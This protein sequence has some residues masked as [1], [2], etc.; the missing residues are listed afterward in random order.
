MPNDRK[1][2][3]VSRATAAHLK[4]PGRH[5]DRSN[6]KVDPVGNPPVYLDE[7]AKMAWA[8]FVEE[9]P[10]LGRSDRAILEMIC[11]LRAKIMGGGS[12]SLPAMTE[13]RQQLSK[14]GASPS[15][16]SKVSAPDGGEE[17]DP[18]SKYVQ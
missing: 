9:L 12:L 6:P 14:L 4:N 7:D 15:D 1:P 3:A 10:W 16:R 17:E 2:V 5:K 11:P 8:V 18:A 13:Y